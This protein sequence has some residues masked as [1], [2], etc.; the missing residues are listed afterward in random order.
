MRI[1]MDVC[2]LNRIFDDLLKIK[3]TNH[4]DYT[5]EREKHLEGITLDEIIQNVKEFD[6]RHS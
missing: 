2:C 1:Y 3:A 6:Q 5:L 4:G